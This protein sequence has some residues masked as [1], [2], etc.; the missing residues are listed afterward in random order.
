MDAIQSLNNTVEVLNKDLAGNL[1]L[2][3]AKHR[4]L[5]DFMVRTVESMKKDIETI[6]FADENSANEFVAAGP[7]ENTIEDLRA[8][9]NDSKNR[10]ILSK[11]TPE[12]IA[13]YNNYLLLINNWASIYQ[14]NKDIND[15]LIEIEVCNKLLTMF[16]SLD[17]IFNKT[18]L[19]ID[20]MTKLVERTN[21]NS[22]AAYMTS[23]TYL[24]SIKDSLNRD[25]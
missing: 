5:R 18:I 2:A 20:T 17:E 3:F 23:A 12:I 15:I 16:N 25:K 13:F 8:V 21:N 1:I 14:D 11:I 19:A 10:L 9:L 7:C 4:G 24:N 22:P 6:I